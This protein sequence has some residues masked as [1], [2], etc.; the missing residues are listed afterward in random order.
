MNQF[1]SGTGNGGILFECLGMMPPG[2]LAGA[3]SCGFLGLHHPPSTLDFHGTHLLVFSLSSLA[4]RSMRA[5]RE[6][7]SLLQE[8]GNAGW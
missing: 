2:R 7:P 8:L 3:L 4:G 1:A 5:L 6:L